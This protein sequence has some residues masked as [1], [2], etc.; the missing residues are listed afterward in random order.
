MTKSIILLILFTLFVGSIDAHE[1]DIFLVIDPD[2]YVNI[3]EKPSSKAKILGQASSKDILGTLGCNLDTFT[4]ISTPNWLPIG[5]DVDG[6]SQV[7]YV[8]KEKVQALYQCP[9]LKSDRD[10]K[11]EVWENDIFSL[12]VTVE[13]VKDCDYIRK[14]EEEDLDSYCDEYQFID[15]TLITGLSL[16]AN[17]YYIYNINLKFNGKYFPFPKEYYQTDI[18]PSNPLADKY[19]PFMLYKHPL[20][21]IYYFFYHIGDGGEYYNKLFTIDSTGIVNYVIYDCDRPI[22]WIGE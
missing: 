19:S 2:G 15:S 3:R 14:K 22:F 11:K 4:P 21:D 7:G 16:N 8:Y 18:F 13:S 20:F 17:S 1:G 10:K 5:V 6:T 12:S 9:R